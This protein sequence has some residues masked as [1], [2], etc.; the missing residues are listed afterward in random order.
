MPWVDS[1]PKLPNAAARL[2]PLRP[3]SLRVLPTNQPL[4][5]LLREPCA[6]LPS[7]LKLPGPP[8]PNQE[9][10]I[11][12]C[13]GADWAWAVRPPRQSAANRIARPSLPAREYIADSLRCGG[14]KRQCVTSGRHLT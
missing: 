3:K 2:N 8:K 14:R 11:Q 5:K 7:R 13:T 6:S 1:E 10:G 4:G 9:L 12:Y